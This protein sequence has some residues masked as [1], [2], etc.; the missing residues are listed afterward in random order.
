[1][2]RDPKP[3][4]GHPM[5]GMVT[6][7]TLLG[8]VLLATVRP[9]RVF[10]TISEH[11]RV[12]WI[13]LIALIGLV[14]FVG[15]P[16]H[17]YEI[18]GVW[19][20]KADPA[21]WAIRTAGWVGYAMNTWLAGFVVLAVVYRW[22]HGAAPPAAPLGLASGY[23]AVGVWFLALTVDALHW[24]LGVPLLRVQMPWFAWTGYPVF[25]NWARLSH[26]VIIPWVSV[27][28]WTVFRTVIGLRGRRQLTLAF[29][30]AVGLPLV[31]RLTLHPL[32]NA[33]AV[34]AHRGLGWEVST[35]WVTLAT[36]VAV[37][38]VLAT[39]LRGWLLLPGRVVV[40]CAETKECA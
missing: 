15:T 18:L 17:I 26:L 12:A 2:R 13:H 8:R 9:H 37:G 40:R 19:F 22:R 16:L 21:Y 10:G 20:F 3:R 1:M 32:P 11:E 33:A 5:H 35:G 34:F 6:F 31:G 36:H 30:L 38:L 39:L 7:R 27:G 14:S 28:L 29:C 23:L 24:L 4:D 25:T